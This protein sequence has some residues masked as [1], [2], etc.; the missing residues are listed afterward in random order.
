M[1]NQPAVD[2]E[3]A[4]AERCRNRTGRYEAWYVT[5]NDP[6][7]RR[8]FWIRYT[9]LNPAPGTG[10]EPQA[11]LWAFGFD[12]D[13]PSRNWGGRQVFP[14]SDMSSSSHPFRLGSNGAELGTGGCAGSLS[15]EHGAA[16]WQ[17]EWTSREPAPFPFMNP[18]FQGIS[19]VANIAAHPQLAV[20][21]EIELDGRTHPLTGAFGGQQHTWGSR[22]ALSWNWGFA[23]GPDFW[24][25]G[26]TSRVRSRLGRVVAGTALGALVA[27]EPFR[28]NG[29]RQV[30]S[31]PGTIS[32]DAWSAVAHVGD[33]RLEVDIRPRREDLIGVTYTDPRGGSRYCYHS[34]VA[35][36]RV[37]FS[38][39][40]RSLAEIHRP[41]A[42][43]FEYASDAPLEG[44]PLTI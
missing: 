3:A 37:S 21:G 24:V 8:G 31:T 13:D 44:V 41:A 27:G 12:H 19:S 30:L 14:L 35:D 11:A 29:L 7:T 23:S 6:S 9:T 10:I 18:R 1:K 38:R 5:V 25:D 40:G 26:V 17:L 42:A 22:H 36:L 15:S 43:A 39:E 2:A 16:R 34:E 32:A 20:T 4:N 28:H 33:R